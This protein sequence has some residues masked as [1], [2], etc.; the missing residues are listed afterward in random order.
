MTKEND[1]ND[2]S[3]LWDDNASED[4]VIAGYQSLI[5]S[6][7]A[8]RLEGHVGRTAMSLIEQG[9]CTLG[10]EGHRDYYGNYVP[11]RHEVLAGTKGSV[12]YV[13]QRR[14]K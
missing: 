4:D 11:S 12:E 3:F 5:D 2:Y 7:M 6:G 14:D 13:Q 9:L 10:E 8:W 1:M